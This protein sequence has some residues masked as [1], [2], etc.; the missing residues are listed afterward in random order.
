M[1][2]IQKREA[3]HN[4]HDFREL[5]RSGK[6]TYSQCAC[7]AEAALTRNLTLRATNQKA[8]NRCPL[9]IRPPWRTE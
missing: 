1:N 5:P 9:T 7:G 4:T 2:T 6:K 3:I 8:I